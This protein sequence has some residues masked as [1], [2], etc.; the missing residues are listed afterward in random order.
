M[1]GMVVS[2]YV[3]YS[4]VNIKDI[5]SF[6]KIISKKKSPTLGLLK[7]IDGSSTN[8]GLETLNLLMDTH[9]PGSGTKNR[10]CYRKIKLTTDKINK[11]MSSIITIETSVLT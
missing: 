3:K 6:N 11:I 8:S 9:F 10:K 7:N 1:G 5:S 4:M 2:T